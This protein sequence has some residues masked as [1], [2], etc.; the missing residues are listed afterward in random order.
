MTWIA[1]ACVVGIAACAALLA[2][3]VER[4]D[5]DP[6][7]APGGASEKSGEDRS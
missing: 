1:S 7:A 4:E 2:L 3:L 6:G 5:G